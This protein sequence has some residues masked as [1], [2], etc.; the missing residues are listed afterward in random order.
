M[1]DSFNCIHLSSEV[2]FGFKMEIKYIYHLF[3]FN[4]NSIKFGSVATNDQFKFNFSPF[5][6]ENAISFAGSALKFEFQA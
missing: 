3:A 1:R 5:Q 6:R 4:R 2:F